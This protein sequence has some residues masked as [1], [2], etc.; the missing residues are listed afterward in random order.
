MKLGV[1]TELDNSGDASDAAEGS[2]EG[3]L[4]VDGA[5][6]PKVKIKRKVK[7]PADKKKVSEVYL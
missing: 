7:K 2:R 5:G 4:G 3:P 6:D 1:A